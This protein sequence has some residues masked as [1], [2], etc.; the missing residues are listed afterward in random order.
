[1]KPGNTE[2]IYHMIPAK[3]KAMHMFPNA[4]HELMRPFDPHHRKVWPLIYI[5]VAQRAGVE[6]EA[7]ATVS[8]AD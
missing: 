6:L 4:G 8:P 7:P 1:M 2:T 5:F 3:D